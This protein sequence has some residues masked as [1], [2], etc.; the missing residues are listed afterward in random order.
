VRRLAANSSLLRD[1]TSVR[2]DGGLAFALGDVSLRALFRPE[3]ELLESL[4]STSRDWSTV[5]VAEGFNPRRVRNCVFQGDVVL[6]RFTRQVPIADDVEVIAGLSGSTLVDCVIGHNALVRDVGL[7]ANYIIGEGAVVVGCGRVTCSSDSSFGN[8]NRVAVAIEE[9][10][11]E[12]D[13]FAEMDVDLAS[14]VARPESRRQ[15]LEGYRRAVADYRD[16][17]R[18]GRGIIGPGARIDNVPRVEDSYIGPMSRI[19]GAT[20]VCRS[21][22]LSTPDEPV[23]I[24]TGG[25]VMDS[26]IQWGCRVTGLAIVERSVLAEQARVERHAKVRDSVIGPNTEVAAGEVVS[27]VLGP[28]VGCHHQSLVISTLWPAGRGNV[29]YGANVG[30]NH[31]SRAPDQEFRAGEGLFIGL[32]V[33]I[34]FPCDFSRAPYT[35]I[36][37]AVNLPPQKV[38][39]PFSLIAHL[40]LHDPDIL[41]GVNQIS[42]GWMLR[43]NIY[44]LKRNEVKF[45]ARNRA[46]RS[47]FDYAVFRRETAELMRTAA[48]SLLDVRVNKEVYTERDIPGLGKNILTEADRVKAV[49]A[50]R[51]HTCLYALHGLMGQAALV[52]AEQF[53]RLLAT[54]SGEETWEYQRQILVHDFAIEDT[55]HALRLLAAMTLQVAKDCERIRE[56]D[57][58]RGA[59]VIDDYPEVHPAVERDRIVR[60]AWDEARKIA[61]AVE[62]Q[63]DLLPAAGGYGSAP[64]TCSF[65]AVD[66]IAPMK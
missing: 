25:L 1:A 34:K 30:S 43:E 41:P 59:R 44:A 42:P 23:V 18:A 37:C 60:H 50:Y 56:K 33:N 66:A 64:M 63:L 14:I 19:E 54:H 47:H 27:T 38:T 45:R 20:A 52:P 36:A 9:G 15:E 12:V 26:L 40:R 4:G 53:S 46:R 7:L 58:L 35:T 22:I 16:H 48:A 55:G 2:A 65:S 49:E 51:F 8:G 61:A 32:G 5:R 13:V 21:S 29:G 6:G 17:A 31:T 57:H 39:F 3:I 62:H 24:E 10:G 11:R 28:F